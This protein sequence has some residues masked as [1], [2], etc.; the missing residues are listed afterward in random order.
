MGY[1]LCICFGRRSCCRPFDWLFGHLWDVVDL[2]AD[3]NNGSLESRN[4][5][6]GNPRPFV[7][8]GSSDRA[9]VDD[10][11]RLESDPSG[12]WC[13]GDVI[14]HLETVTD[15]SL[16]AP[17]FFLHFDGCVEY[18]RALDACYCVSA[19]SLGVVKDK[20]DRGKV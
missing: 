11:A 7:S 1:V 20:L 16:V 14:T 10:S 6:G 12:T 2:V 8:V 15:W 17:L 19:S 13:V 18:F 9:E 4:K 3:E 5:S